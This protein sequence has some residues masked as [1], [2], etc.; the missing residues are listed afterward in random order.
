[1]GRVFYAQSG[2]SF[3]PQ[4]GTG[5][6]GKFASDARRFSGKNQS[7]SGSEELSLEER[8]AE[9]SGRVVSGPQPDFEDHELVSGRKEGDNRDNSVGV[10]AERNALSSLDAAS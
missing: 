8:R 3:E 9:I 5:V 2:T 1:M 6:R 10:P 4:D 7:C